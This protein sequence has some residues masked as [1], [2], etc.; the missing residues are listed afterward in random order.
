MSS[1]NEVVKVNGIHAMNNG[2][3]VYSMCPVRNTDLINQFIISENEKKPQWYTGLNLLMDIMDFDVD[4]DNKLVYVLDYEFCPLGIYE[5]SHTFHDDYNNEDI[6]I[7]KMEFPDTTHFKTVN[8]NGR[9]SVYHI[10]EWS[11]N[12]RLYDSIREWLINQ[13]TI[14][15]AIEGRL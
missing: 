11:N 3:Y 1:I 4:Y 10:G 13:N 9:E 8:S 6:V 7:H 15:Q 12:K 5:D 14:R 2:N